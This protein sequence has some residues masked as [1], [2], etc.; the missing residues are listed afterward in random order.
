[1]EFPLSELDPDK[2][3]DDERFPL[4]F[5]VEVNNILFE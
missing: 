3:K 1:M 4:N 5:K 2:R